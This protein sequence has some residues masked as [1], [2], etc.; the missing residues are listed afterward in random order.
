MGFEYVDEEGIWLYK[1]EMELLLSWGLIGLDEYVSILLR[2]DEQWRREP[3]YY[4]LS[5]WDYVKDDVD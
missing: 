5:P 4:R 3:T 1:Q 2:L